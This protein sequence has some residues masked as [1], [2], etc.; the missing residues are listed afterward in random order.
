MSSRQ[1]RRLQKQREL[2]EASTRKPIVESDQGE[3]GSEDEEPAPPATRPK[4][5]LFAALGGDDDN[6]DD[7]D[8]DEEDEGG[9]VIE[10][11][12]ASEPKP[13]A[14]AKKS[15]KKKKAKKKAAAAD[16]AAAGSEEED[17]IDKAIKALKTA[18]VGKGD[19][20]AARDEDR[21]RRAMASNGILQINTYHL[22]A[23]NEMR[24]LFG[25][26]VIESAEA[27]E[28]Q[29]QQQ[30]LRGGRGTQGLQLD[31][32]TFL[33][34]Q[35]PNAKKLPEVS[36]RR[37]VF[38]QGRDH[39][40]A[41]S[42]GGLTMKQIGAADGTTTE[43][44]YLH[45]GGYDGLQTL[46]FACVQLGDPMRMVHL[47]KRAP[48]HVSTLLQV[49]AV[50][51][52]DQNN[53]LSAE[54]CERALFAFG[55]VTT[56]AFRRDLERGRA[57][58]DFRRPENRQ[59]WL[60]GYHYLRSLLRKGTYRTALE[61]ARLLYALDPRGDPYAMRHYLHFLAVRA[62]ESAW[63]LEFLQDVEEEEEGDGGVAHEDFVYV[64][65]SA[66]LA[67]LQ[68]GETETAR[69]ELAEGMRR[70]PWLYCALFQELGLDA[71]PS[72]WG[73]HAA[74]DAR[75]FWV[76]LYL[77]FAK[78]LWNNTQ[79]TALLVQVAKGL[80]EKV[81]VADLPVD[82]APPGLDATRLVYLEGQT[83]L[84]ALAPRALL[85]RQP[86]YDFDPM[87]P[88]EEDNVF[89]YL[90][91]ELPWAERRQR[92]AGNDDN[93]TVDVQEV[94]E[95]MRNNLIAQGGGGGGAGR[96]VQ[97]FGVAGQIEDESDYDEET[98]EELRRD[99]EE[100]ARRS[101]EPGY[102][103]Q[104]MQLIGIGGGRGGDPAAAT[105][106]EGG[107]EE[108]DDEVPGAWPGGQEAGRG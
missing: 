94:L 9:A 27:E 24:N 32:E 55:R 96:P 17:E 86:N 1:L 51:R 63:L 56:S 16:A 26:E 11:A 29:Q 15:K 43:Y 58:L 89:T 64:R 61:W 62:H 34:L 10:P 53:A 39:W 67:R 23:V 100:H 38:V 47:L 45:E 25:R 97:G 98:D 13:S 103:N 48:Y 93:N 50:A 41:E 104:L 95:R 14:S 82:D 7:D 19:A 72:I 40:P 30:R 84:I 101:R 59:L 37:N 36:L 108:E 42:A 35:P 107:V 90:G 76:K 83:G 73:I 102:L 44:A 88:A 28:E 18:S 22:R 80:E 4:T 78:D 75:Q 87:P 6:D 46:F 31:L 69:K 60:A 3:K 92:S 49:S 66:V 2:E 5:N 21:E 71:P 85:D 33:R 74:S 20:A 79:A 57:R 65:Q 81:R 77:H 105:Q 8:A 52:Q 91:T 68:M 106:G 70:V 54:L 99:L 12:A